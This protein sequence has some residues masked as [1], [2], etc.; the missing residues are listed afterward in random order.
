MKKL[1]ISILVNTLI[2][3]RQYYYRKVKKYA[4]NTT[5]MPTDYESLEALVE[6]NKQF[7]FGAAMFLSSKYNNTIRGFDY[8]MWCAANPRE[9]ERAFATVQMLWI[10]SITY[11]KSYGSDT[12]YVM[13]IEGSRTKKQRE[14]FDARIGMLS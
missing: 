8:V 5:F 1:I 13:T 6:D 3:L 11:R 9:A 7:F 12:L 2:D 10:V 14:D 4:V